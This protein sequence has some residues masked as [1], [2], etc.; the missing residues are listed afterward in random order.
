MAA[1]IAPIAM[2][3]ATVAILCALVARLRWHQVR[4]VIAQ[5][6]KT[7][8]ELFSVR[9]CPKCHSI[10]TQTGLKSVIGKTRGIKPCAASCWGVR[11]S[12]Q[13][14]LAL[15]AVSGTIRQQWS[16]SQHR[17]SNSLGISLFFPEAVAGPGRVSLGRGSLPKT[18]DQGGD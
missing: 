4:S 13:R 10:P 12:S 11:S 6:G 16:H 7:T 9:V 8:T 3:V 18:S 17:H 14:R 2:M 15:E 1:S 5:C